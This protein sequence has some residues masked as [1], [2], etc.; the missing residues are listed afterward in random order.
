LVV[1]ISALS[2]WSFSLHPPDCTDSPIPN[3]SVVVEAESI[4]SHSLPVDSPEKD[5]EDE[6]NV[7]ALGDTVSIPVVLHR[8]DGQGGKSVR[9]PAAAAVASS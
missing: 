7:S 9:E 8:A 2:L 3:P 1:S 6:L 4:D 5:I